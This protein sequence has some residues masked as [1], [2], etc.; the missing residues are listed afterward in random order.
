[1][2]NVKFSSRKMDDFQEQQLD[3]PASEADELAKYI[4]DL[5]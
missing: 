4:N 5:V 1:M 2:E 3:F